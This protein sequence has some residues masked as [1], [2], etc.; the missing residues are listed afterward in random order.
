MTPEQEREYARLLPKLV[1]AGDGPAIAAI[2]PDLSPPEAMAAQAFAGDKKSV[3]ARCGVLGFSFPLWRFPA[4]GAVGTSLLEQFGM[5][6]LS[7]VTDLRDANLPDPARDEFGVG[8]CIEKDDNYIEYRRAY[9]MCA[10]QSGCLVIRN[11]SYFFG[12]DRLPWPA[13][14]AD[15]QKTFSGWQTLTPVD[16]ADG[17][18]FKT[19]LPSVASGLLD[20]LEAFDSDFFGWLLGDGVLPLCDYLR[21][22]LQHGRGM[23]FIGWVANGLPPWMPVEVTPLTDDLINHLQRTPADFKREGYRLALLSGPNGD[24]PLA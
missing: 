15:D 13:A 21:G 2:F 6:R 5:K 3:A 10:N 22:K 4:Q 14:F 9:L 7:R 24:V 18:L 17:N 23:P 19:T 12:R 20:R 11:S 8:F 16:F 1:C